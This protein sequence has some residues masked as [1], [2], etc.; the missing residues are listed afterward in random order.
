MDVLNKY[1]TIN[2]MV[3]VSSS[4]WN[5]V[6]GA[7][8]EDV[9]KDAEG[10]QTMRNLARNMAWIMKCIEAGKSAGID[11]PQTERGSRTNFIR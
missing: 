8:P 10:L 3:V 6:H 5:V 1:F 7:T 9:K 2:E 11:V 4:Y